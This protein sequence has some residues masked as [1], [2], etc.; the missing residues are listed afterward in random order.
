MPVLSDTS[1]VGVPDTFPTAVSPLGAKGFKSAVC[2]SYELPE[3]TL[4]FL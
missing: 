2:L 4:D 1:P 3:N